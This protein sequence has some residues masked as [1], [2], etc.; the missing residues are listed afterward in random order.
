MDGDATIVAFLARH[1][2][3]CVNYAQM[4]IA[5]T[6]GRILQ[7]YKLAQHLIVRLE[8]IK[9]LCRIMKEKDI[10]M[11]GVAI[12]V[13]V[14]VAD[15]DGFVIYVTLI[16]ALIADKLMARDKIYECVLFLYLYSFSI[17]ISIIGF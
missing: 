16:I 8:S 11:D 3:G 15:S 7:H 17:W 9:W 13:V 5:L 6:V 12:F 2:D 10:G 14:Q 1:T 4:I